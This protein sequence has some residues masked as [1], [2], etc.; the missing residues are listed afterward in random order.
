M[1]NNGPTFTKA[2]YD[3]RPPRY[4]PPSTARVRVAEEQLSQECAER[5]TFAKL[6]STERV[7]I[8]V[9]LALGLR[10]PAR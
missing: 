7:G 9:R 5:R 3:N 2:T 8:L 4:D 6:P 10:Y 1:S